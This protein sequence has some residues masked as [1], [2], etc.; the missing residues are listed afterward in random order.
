MTLLSRLLR[1]TPKGFPRQ[2]WVRIPPD[3][4]VPQ[5]RFLEESAYL[6]PKDAQEENRLN[7]QHYALTL[8]LGNHYLAPLPPGV[9]VIVDSGTGTRIWCVEMARAFPQSLVLG[10]DI[11]PALFGTRPPDNC[12][13]RAGN[14]LSGLPLPE[15]FAD[16]THQRFLVLA[17]PDERWPGVVRELVRVTRAGG[18]LELVETDA[19][20]QA[21]GPATEQMMAW[22]DALRAARG[23]RGE[24]VLHLGELL[25]QEGVSEIETQAIPLKVGAW[26]GRA[27]QMMAQDIL[28]AV[29]ALKEPCCARGIDPQTFE[30]CAQAMAGECQQMQLF[31]TV[32]V[33]YGRHA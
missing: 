15:Q 5:R 14:I 28:A 7:F 16:F 10:F 11:D 24:A 12:L 32:Y 2:P 13:L 19:R 23:L 1:R 29:Q 31:C 17:L 6:L 18:W 3:P 20:L 22:L 27:G 30:N 33:A 9:R 4:V 8:T 25:Q 21:G 26:G